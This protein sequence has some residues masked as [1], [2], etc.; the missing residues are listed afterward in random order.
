[1]QVHNAINY[2][3]LITTYMH[4]VVRAV[5]FYFNDCFVVRVQI[6]VSCIW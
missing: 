3:A 2:F 6:Y 4:L 1:M 5:I